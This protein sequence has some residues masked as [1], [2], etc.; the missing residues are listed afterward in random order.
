MSDDEPKIWQFDVTGTL[1]LLWF[2]DEGRVVVMMQCF[3]KQGGKRGKTPQKL[4]RKAQ[5]LCDCYFAAK[6]NGT[7]EI[8]SEG[9]NDEDQ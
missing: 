7:L 3:Y 8:K 1:R 4:V 5:R 2:Y 9:S 6:R